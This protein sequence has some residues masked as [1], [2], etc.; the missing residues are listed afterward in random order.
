MDS[1]S[2]LIKKATICSFV[3]WESPTHASQSIAS[4]S[5]ISSRYNAITLFWFSLSW[6]ARSFTKHSFPYI[7]HEAQIKICC[8][9]NP[10]KIGNLRISSMI[11]ATRANF[12]GKCKACRCFHGEKVQCWKAAWASFQVAKRRMAR[13]LIHNGSL[14]FFLQPEAFSTR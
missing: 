5:H 4:C 7:F 12:N 6:Q 10:R 9:C 8:A 2:K 14:S 3:V 1:S 11:H 13:P